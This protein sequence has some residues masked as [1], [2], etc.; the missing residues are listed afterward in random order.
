MGS[1]EPWH[2]RQRIGLAIG[3]VNVC[4]N[5]PQADPTKLELMHKQFQVKK[6]E[7]KTQVRETVLDKV[8]CGISSN[9]HQA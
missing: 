2:R 8:C 3:S 9:S 4:T 6:E 5:T 7:F 1:L